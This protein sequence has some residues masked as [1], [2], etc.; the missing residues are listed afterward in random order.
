MGT[1]S[2]AAGSFWNDTRHSAYP[3][4]G[5]HSAKASLLL[6]AVRE[7]PSGHV[8][9]QNITLG[10]GKNEPGWILC[11][12][13]YGDPRHGLSPD[14]PA[15]YQLERVLGLVVRATDLKTDSA[16]RPEQVARRNQGY[17]EIVDL[18]WCQRR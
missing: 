5:G 10:Y 7:L 4:E 18:A 15:C 9:A 17:V 8:C 6:A 14:R 16:T 11:V 2:R 1:E 12:A 13:M 3:A